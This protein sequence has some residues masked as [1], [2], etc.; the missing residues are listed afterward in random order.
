MLRFYVLSQ[1]KQMKLEIPYLR[2]K[3]FVQKVDN[4][5]KAPRQLERGKADE[6]NVR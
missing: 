3:F 1:V 2:F 5:Q 4:Y 6:F